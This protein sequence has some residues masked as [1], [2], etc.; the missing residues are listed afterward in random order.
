MSKATIERLATTDVVARASPEIV[1]P[2]HRT[3]TG[4]TAETAARKGVHVTALEP[5]AKLLVRT[6]NTEYHLT[7]V[8]PDEWQVLVR[9]G[10]F[11][12]TDTLAFLC[13]S[14]F[15]GALL[16]VAWIGVGLSCEFSSQGLRIV[17]SPVKDFHVLEVSLPGPF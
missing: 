17:T 12:R 4:F 8:D 15:G 11:F 2:Q 16:K 3:L 14:G 6:R 5:F 10:R 9:G 7:I 1:V 13:G